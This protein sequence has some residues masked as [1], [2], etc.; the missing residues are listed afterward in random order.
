MSELYASLQQMGLQLSE[1]VFG[2]A[3]GAPLF[4]IVKTVLLIL[5]VVIPLML[6]IAYLTLWERK[7]I[8]WMQIRIGPNRVGPMGLLQ[9][10]ADGIKLFLKEAGAEDTK[11]VDKLTLKSR[12]LAGKEGEVV[13]LSA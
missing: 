7:L 3:W 2:V 4:T 5:C 8:G 10:I 13:V 9:P 12:D 1:S 6:S 11:P